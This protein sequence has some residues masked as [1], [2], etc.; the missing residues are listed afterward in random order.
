M[1]F[2]SLAPL[3]RQPALESAPVVT[4]PQSGEPQPAP[5]A[6]AGDQVAMTTAK[7]GTVPAT[8]AFSDRQRD[9]FLRAGVAGDVETLRRLLAEGVDVNVAND[10]GYTAL[11]YAA[12][13]GQLE[14]IQVL[15]DAGANVNAAS[16]PAGRTVLM[17]AAG[18]GGADAVKLLL[19]A[20]PRLEDRDGAGRT[21]LMVAALAG[22]KDAAF[23]LF[24]GGADP[25][26]T[27]A[28]GAKASQLAAELG[29]TWVASLL[30]GAEKMRPPVKH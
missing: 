9:A 23:A 11:A 22:D 4:R 7:T 12:S 21:A 26:A 5:A 8:F 24:E 17:D 19:T 13:N 2:D 14:A 18:R 3:T 15:L 29:H 27:D 30:R 28:K 20:K 10:Y 6:L 16:K 25:H 1:A